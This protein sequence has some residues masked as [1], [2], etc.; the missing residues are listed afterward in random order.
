MAKIK[1]KKDD[2]YGRL[3]KL[4]D[5]GMDTL[6]VVADSSAHKADEYFVT[7]WVNGGPVVGLTRE[8]AIDFA[9][10]LLREAA[11]G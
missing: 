3:L 11:S 10:A 6:H 7:M 4:V 5:L 2:E 9:V 8:A 1:F